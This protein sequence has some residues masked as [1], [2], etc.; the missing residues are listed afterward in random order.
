MKN[1][2]QLNQ[3]KDIKEM[4]DKASRFSS[5]SGL[6]IIISGVFALIGAFLIYSDLEFVLKDG[7]LIG[8]SQLIQGNTELEDLR[9]I[10]FLLIIGVII[11]ISSSLIC[12][13][14]SIRQAKKKK[15]EF[16]NSTFK[17]ALKALFVP[18]ITGGIF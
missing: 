12:Y 17:R 14:L 5:L 1:K 4:M 15:V 10:K 11:F 16:W 3:I 7:K 6:S 2:E 8:Y 9:K 18:L 13:I